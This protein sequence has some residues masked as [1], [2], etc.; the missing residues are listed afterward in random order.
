MFLALPGLAFAAGGAW[1]LVAVR[2]PWFDY[3]GWFAVLV[4]CGVANALTISPRPPEEVLPGPRIPW[5]AL[6]FT[7]K[8]HA[9]RWERLRQP[10]VLVHVAVLATLIAWLVIRSLVTF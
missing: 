7:H 5:L 9:P 8:Q 6:P 10:E 3:W 1:F 2:M 4:A